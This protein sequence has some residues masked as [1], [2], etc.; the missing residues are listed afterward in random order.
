VDKKSGLFTLVLVVLL[1][2]INPGL[3]CSAEGVRCEGWLNQAI[4]AGS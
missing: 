2:G 4:H 3:F 1:V